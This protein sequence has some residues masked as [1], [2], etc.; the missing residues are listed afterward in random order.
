MELGTFGAI[1]GFAMELEQQAA[2]FYE[3][4]AADGLEEVFLELARG[5]RKRLARLERAR[6]E[7]VTEMILES[8]TG[9]DGDTY[10]VNLDSEIDE[11]G[12]LR[13]A[14][15]L[16]ETSAR[17]YRDAADK[18]PIREVVRLFQR[19]VRENEQRQAQLGRLEK[20]EVC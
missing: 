7:M 5:S 6:R 11:A 19:L 18:M 10:G 15:T 1:L 8:I 9:L 14:W 13:Q 20:R 4:W 12:L 16:E 17:F 2:D 3:R